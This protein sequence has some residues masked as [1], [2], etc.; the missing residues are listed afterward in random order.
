MNAQEILNKAIAIGQQAYNNHPDE[1]YCGFAWVNIKG[2]T[3]FARAIKKL[4]NSGFRT[5]S[6]AGGLTYWVTGRSQS[7]ARKEKFAQAMAL[8][9]TESGIPAQWRSR[10]D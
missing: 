5:D 7:M 10:A 3:A 9:L 4:P 2:N 1:A 8:S 6:Y